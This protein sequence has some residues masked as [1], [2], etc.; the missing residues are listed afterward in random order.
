MYL[1][2][3]QR[4]SKL[5]W[6]R[7][8]NYRVINKT[9]PISFHLKN[10]LAG[11]VIKAHTENIRLAEIDNWEIPKYRKGRLTGRARFVAPLSSS[12]DEIDNELSDDERPLSK[13]AKK[14][15]RGRENFF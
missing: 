5:E 10:Q 15:R 13:I 12:F 8:P 1:K 7:C 6:R 4:K 3:Q 14:Y 11:S 9:S 2:Q